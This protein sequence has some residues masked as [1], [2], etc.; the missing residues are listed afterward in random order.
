MEATCRP[1]HLRILG[2]LPAAT[3]STF[4]SR[5]P[6]RLQP[7]VQKTYPPIPIPARP[8]IREALPHRTSLL[9]KSPLPADPNRRR[10]Y[11]L[12][13]TIDFLR[14]RPQ[15]HVP[16][17]SGLRGRAPCSPMRKTRGRPCVRRRYLREPR[18]SLF[19]KQP[20]TAASIRNRRAGWAWALVLTLIWE[21]TKLI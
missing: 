11:D 2:H 18:K 9:H 1:L 6:C 20:G 12:R 5:A 8:R 7:R 3:P 10:R 19:D 17:L 16:S 15:T 13:S 21:T 4:P 14:K